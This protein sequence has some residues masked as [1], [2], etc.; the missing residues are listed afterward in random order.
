MGTRKKLCAA[1]D[2]LDYFASIPFHYVACLY[3]FER[4][5]E[6]FLLEEYNPLVRFDLAC[7]SDAQHSYNWPALYSVHDHG[8]F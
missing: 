6:S 5:P 8:F 2:D 1:Y 4:F 3:V 7:R